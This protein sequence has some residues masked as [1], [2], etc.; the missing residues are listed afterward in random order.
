[1]FMYFRKY[2][3]TWVEYPCPQWYMIHSTH[4]YR[5][6]R[7]NQERRRWQRDIDDGVTLRKARSPY[8]LDAR[9]LDKTATCLE[10]KSW[11]KLYRKKKQWL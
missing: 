9:N 4:Y 7:T 1:M 2:R 10:M 11:K 6:I 3:Q 5:R 8:Y